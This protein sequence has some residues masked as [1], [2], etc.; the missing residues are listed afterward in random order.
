MKK[1]KKKLKSQEEE[2]LRPLNEDGIEILKKKTVKDLISPSGIDASNIDHM[3]IISN[4]KRYARH[5]QRY[6]PIW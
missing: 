3:E 1:N 5:I 2:Q 4:T 6:V